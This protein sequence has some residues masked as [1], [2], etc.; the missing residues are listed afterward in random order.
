MI[1]SYGQKLC[2]HL[3]GDHWVCPAMRSPSGRIDLSFAYRVTAEWCSV[4]QLTNWNIASR[5]RSS[6]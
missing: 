1:F 4:L 5:E 2:Y 6:L 3:L